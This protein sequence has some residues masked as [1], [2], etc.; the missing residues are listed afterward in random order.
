MMERDDETTQMRYA[1]ALADWADAGGYE[2]EVALGRLHRRRARHP[3]RAGAVARG[4]HAVRR[5]AEAAGARGAAARARTRCCCSTSRTTTSTCPAK[6]WLEERLR[7][8]PKTVLF[9]SHDRELLA[10][11]ATRIVTLELGAAGNTRRGCTAAA[12]RPTTQ[13]RRGPVRPAR[14]AAPALGRGARQAQ[15]A[16]ADV[17]AEG[18][19]QRR[20]GRRATRR[21]ETRLREVRGGRPAARRIP[22]EQNVQ[23]RLRGG[24]TGKRAVVCEEL[25]L[26]GLMKPF[27]LEVWYGE[28]VAVLGSQRLGQ[29]ALPAAAGRRRQRPR[30]RAPAGRRR[31]RSRR[32]RTPG[33]ARLGARVRPGWFA[34]THE[35]PELVGRTL[36]E[37]LH[38]GDEHRAGHGPRAGGPGAGPLRARARAPSRRSSRCPAASRRGSRSCCSSCPAPPCCCSTSRPTTSTCESAEALEEGL[39]AFEGTVLAVTHDRWF[40]R[41]F[42]RFLVFGADGAGLRVRRAGLGRGPGAAGPVTAAAS[43]KWGVSSASPTG[44]R[45]EPLTP[46]TASPSEPLMRLSPRPVLLAVVA[47]LL[48]LVVPLAAN[49]AGAD[50]RHQGG[51]AGHSLR[52]G[53]TDENFYFVMA[54]RFANGD[55]GQRPRRPHRRPAGDRLRPDRQGLLP[56][57]RPQG[58]ASTSSTTSRASARPRSG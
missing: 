3:V 31:R 44:L 28:R 29:V 13:A 39:D 41:G 8:S 56:R 12:S 50:P 45:C 54:D 11:A 15:G 20:H 27:D 19:L 24:R 37:I 5:R 53:V 6:R 26:T 57:R 36:L 46:R 14:G 58:P 21:R 18:G 51:V 25:E 47:L 4:A 9:V 38:R 16:G 7:E 35:H 55:T 40:A 23:M 17:Q 49:P 52:A 22:R 33:G 34:Q 1:Q 43:P 32:S 2:A 30:R 42:D 10:R 48:G